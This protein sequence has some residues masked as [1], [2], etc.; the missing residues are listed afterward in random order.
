MLATYFTIGSF[1][2]VEVARFGFSYET[3]NGGWGYEIV[4]IYKG[5]VFSRGCID[6][7][8]SYNSD[9]AIVLVMNDAY[10]RLSVGMP[11][12]AGFKN[13]DAAV[14]RAIVYKYVF[15]VGICLHE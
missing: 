13:V 14:G 5:Y 7:L 15:K 6:A 1:D 2:N 8:L 12:Y 4:A 9:A 10:L 3:L 11:F